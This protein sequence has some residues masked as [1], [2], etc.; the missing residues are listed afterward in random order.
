MSDILPLQNTDTQPNVAASSDGDTQAQS[1]TSQPSSNS[2]YDI[3][4]FD[5]ITVLKN[6]VEEAKLPQQLK[7]KAQGMILRLIK[8]S[9][10]GNFSSE[11]EPVSEYI[12]WITK[13]PFGEYT[14]DNIEI[15]QVKA[16]LDKFNYGLEPVKSRILEYLAVLKLQNKLPE[17][18]DGTTID[19]SAEMMRLQGNSS[20]APILCFVGIQ[21]VG[22]TSMAKAIA[23]ALDRKFM[24]ISLGGMGNVT[25]IRGIPRGNMDAEP[26]QIVKSLIRTGV[27]NP[28]ILLDEIDKTSAQ[29]G[30]R[31]DV[32]A[33][34]L[35]IL[36]PEQNSTFMDKY[37][38]YPL[39]L[40]QCIFIC[41]AN[42]LGG[43]TAALLD[44]LE[45]IR[46]GSYTDSDKVMIA[47]NYL[48]PKVRE[49]TG[50]GEDQ[51]S[52]A[53]DVW[54]MVIRPLGFDAGVRQLERT[55]TELARKVAL[56]IVRGTVKSVQ[57]TKDNFRQFIPEDI[58]VY[59]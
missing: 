40:S 17:A 38:D 26:G 51:L 44:R 28:L 8:M 33:A 57:I 56:Q 12:N 55:L 24:R 10:K 16:T 22:K 20:H 4:V 39:D 2:G 29:S 41:T 52:F 47:K 31:T 7:E 3:D 53:D 9:Q 27:M 45:V 43:I 18:S 25:E 42:N 6:K 5:E 21:G 36:D 48:L 30:V 49:A 11:F 14:T 54:P 34:L 46:F 58:G 59:S 37:L 15:D 35:E 13:I 50:L 19:V 1:A 23:N 32:M